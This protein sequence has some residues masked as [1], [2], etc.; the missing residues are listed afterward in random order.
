MRGRMRQ[1]P[2]YVPP[3]TPGAPMQGRVFAEVLAAPA[4]FVHAPGTRGLVVAPWSTLFVLGADAA[5]ALSPVPAG[6]GPG[7]ALGL[8]GGTGLAAYFGLT[9]IGRPQRGETL[10]VSG[11]A[12]ATGSTVVQLGRLLGCRGG[13][14]AGGADKCAF[15][16]SLGAAAVVDYK[17]GDVAAALAAACPDG[18]DIYFDN[19]GGEILQAAFALMRP[20]GRIVACGSISG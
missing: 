19:V 4:G 13:G 1:A 2:S 3:F 15:A 18:I 16:A 9:E 14:I 7:V 17:A 10:V 20:F 11:A 5:A 12:G 6:T 8:L